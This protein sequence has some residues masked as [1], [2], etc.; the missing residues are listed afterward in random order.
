MNQ[1]TL[2][3]TQ[4]TYYSTNNKTKVISRRI[5]CNAYGPQLTKCFSKKQKKKGKQKKKS[6]LQL[7]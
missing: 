5:I 3:K 2:Q 4:A 1:E 7:T 6:R